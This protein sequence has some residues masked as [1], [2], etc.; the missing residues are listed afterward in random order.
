M[1]KVNNA[2]KNNTSAVKNTEEKFRLLL[3]GEE[4]EWEY[5]MLPLV[6][7][8]FGEDEPVIDWL[9]LPECGRVWSDYK[10]HSTF[11]SLY[12]GEH[13]V[14]DLEDDVF[15]LIYE[16]GECPHYRCRAL[17]EENRPDETV[18]SMVFSHGLATPYGGHGVS[19]K[20][21]FGKALAIKPEHEICCSLEEQQIGAFGVA[22]K[23]TVEIGSNIDLYSF[24]EDGER[25]FDPD[26]WRTG[27]LVRTASDIDPTKWDHCEFI[28]KEVKLQYFW[29]K[30]W[31]L[32]D[33]EYAK[34][35]ETLR[36]LNFELRVV[37]A[38]REKVA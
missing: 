27:S 8:E 15:L 19:A 30:E 10:S 24:V 22:V 37:K 21:A 20:E 25:V 5:S 29:I 17:M 18:Q 12:E 31:A 7:S 35:A 34:L 9:I 36:E 6:I 1:A 33:P 16:E 26:S 2:V 38:R 13:I 28:V 32:Q 3:A 4:V 14:L 23:G 11:N